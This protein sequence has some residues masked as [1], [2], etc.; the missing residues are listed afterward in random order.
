M[1]VTY[2]VQADQFQTPPF[3]R[4]SFI[5]QF[6]HAVPDLVLMSGNLIQFVVR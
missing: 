3:L 1:V 2:T 4:R 5:G 6:L